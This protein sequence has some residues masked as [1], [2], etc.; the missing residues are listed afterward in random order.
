MTSLLDT[1]LIL[2]IDLYS[3]HLTE[4]LILT[5]EL[6]EFKKQVILIS[7]L[8]DRSDLCY[9]LDQR[10]FTAFAPRGGSWFLGKP[11]KIVYKF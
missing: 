8:E 9:I 3:W 11:L 4:F 2:K 6:G 1:Q 10:G 5:A 7:V